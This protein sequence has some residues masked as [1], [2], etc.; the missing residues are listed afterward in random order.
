MCDM[1]WRSV[2]R[3]GVAERGV[4]SWNSG[5]CWVQMSSIAKCS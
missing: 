5:R 2:S 1:D 3:D 4:W